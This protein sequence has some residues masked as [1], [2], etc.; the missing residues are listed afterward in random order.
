MSAGQSNPYGHP[1]AAAIDLYS[2]FGQVRR[3][4]QEGLVA[5]SAADLSGRR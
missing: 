2:R 1:T 3:T 4:D 5:I